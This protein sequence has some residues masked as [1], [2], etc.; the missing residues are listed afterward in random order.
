MTA[1]H[2]PKRRFL[3]PEVV[4]TSAM[5]CG[6]A[7]LKCLLD[8]F[9]IDA[10]YGRL[11]EACQ[12]DVDGTSIDT[13]EEIAIQLGLDAE[14]IMLPEDHLLLP[15]ANALPA[16]IVVRLPNGFTHFVVAWRKHGSRF[17][18]IMD[19]AVGRRWLT[20][21]QF[22]R[23]VYSHTFPVPAD[24]WREWAGSEAFLAPLRR[25][26]AEIGIVGDNMNAIVNPVIANTDWLPLAALDAATRMVTALV[27][28]GGVA[29]GEAAAIAVQTFL[30]QTK[31]SENLDHTPIPAAYWSVRP[32]P[33]DEDGELQLALRGAVLVRIKGKLPA[34]AESVEGEKRPLSPELVAA[35]EEPPPRPEQHLLHMLFADG[36]RQPIALLFATL[37]AAGGVFIEALLFR[38]LIDIG[39]SL[40]LV[41]QRAGAILA[42]LLFIFIYLLLQFRNTSHALRLGRTLEIHFRIAFLQKIPRLH[43]R[44]FHSRPTSDMA[45]RSHFIHKL[46]NLPNMSVAVVRNAFTLLFITLGI[47][48]LSPQS[49][50][51]A[52]ITALAA[53]GM[54]LLTL[55]LLAERDMRVQTHVGALSRSFLDA[56]LG[57]VAI[58]AHNAEQSMRRE[59]ESLLVEWAH[60][61]LTLYK[62]VVSVEGLLALVTYLPA[63]LLLFNHLRQGG[64]TSSILLLVYWVLTLP[65]LGQEIGTIM[66]QYPTYRN[67]T[68]R[69]L[70]PLTA[71]EDE[72]L[73]SVNNHSVNNHSVNNHRPA[74]ADQLP[75]KTDSKNDG[76]CIRMDHVSVIAAGH[77][78]LEDITLA[79][80]AGQHVAIVGPSGAGKSTLV[81]LLQG[82]HR[83]A[84]GTLSVDDAALNGEALLRLRQNTAW[85]DPAVQLWNR[86]FKDNLLYGSTMRPDLPLAQV[87]KQADLLAVLQKLPA[88]W[89]TTLG[90]GGGLVSGG[91]GQRMRLGRALLRAD[92][93]LVILDE[94]FRGLDAVQRR[95]LLT[96]AR[97]L[98]QQA[99]LLCI[100]HDVAETKAFPR[101]LVIE[102]GHL[103]EDGVPDQLAAQPE[104]RY[105]DLLTAET[106]LRQEM[107]SSTYWRKLRLEN[108]QLVQMGSAP[109]EVAHA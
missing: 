9:H 104:S 58:K 25:R 42:V 36:R 62:T 78:I 37:L 103:I 65:E 90:E 56:M 64:E 98:W 93:R 75:P 105:G 12:T 33:P 4:Q 57:L 87:I 46:R 17:I 66:R 3:I 70:E 38:G 20:I 88:G 13:M 27:R 45:Q 32:L 59:H 109:D 49:T 72:N 80:P 43:D 81:G 8:G 92:V 2:S 5:D 71:P 1:V 14:Q 102:N 22:L 50:F 73:T 69:L 60:A 47:I 107:W 6:P 53:V 89:Q 86:S 94:P 41:W 15:E 82:W 77:T 19:P 95:D 106:K 79:I 97:Q 28:A 29:R 40:G 31:Q 39:E 63:I 91:E 100:T 108:G 101:V 18:Q 68:L 61:A 85:V 67:I 34:V 23:S 48:W 54:P 16:L 52:I 99:T 10:S 24:G 74:L 21:P 83:P 55:P 11:R 76:V 7:A 51:L 84:H 35:L 26:L 96:L 44:Y 30:D